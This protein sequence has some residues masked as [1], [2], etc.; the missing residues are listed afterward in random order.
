M[1][2]IRDSIQEFKHLNGEP[3]HETWPRF[4]KMVLKFPTHG[5]PDKFLLKYFYRSLDLEKKGVADQLSPGG[6]MQ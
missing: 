3:L 6:L 2:I 4:L 1:M 5:L